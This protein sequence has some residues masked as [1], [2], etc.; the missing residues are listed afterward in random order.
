M[1]NDTDPEQTSKY[2]VPTGRRTPGAD[3]IRDNGFQNIRRMSH[4]SL[5]ALVVGVGATTGALAASTHSKAVG[6]AAV[7]TSIGSPTSTL[8]TA[9]GGP[10][11]GSPVATTSASGVTISTSASQGGSP[12]GTNSARLTVAGLGDS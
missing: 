6:T 10:T 4:W 3:A 5:A 11:V 1:P 2:A 7:T 9:Q 12:S 8:S